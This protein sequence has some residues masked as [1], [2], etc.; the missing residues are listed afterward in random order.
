MTMFFAAV[1]GST[2][3]GT[4]VVVVAGKSGV[5]V[6]CT[7]AF[8][9][10]DSGGGAGTAFGAD[11]QERIPAIKTAQTNAIAYRD[12]SFLTIKPPLFAI[13]LISLFNYRT[14]GAFCKGELEKDKFG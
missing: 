1:F 8:A 12:R 9:R 10:S 7:I 3:F 14:R 6:P 2:G 13:V 5:E 11:V 4:V